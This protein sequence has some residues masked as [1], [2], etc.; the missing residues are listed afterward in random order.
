MKNNLRYIIEI[1]NDNEQY[2]V[3]NRRILLHNSDMAKTF[4][5]YRSA[6]NYYK[7]SEHYKNDDTVRI[8]KFDKSI[9]KI[10]N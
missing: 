6:Y 8:A 4:P 1:T 3:F 2:Y 7:H 10:V 9:N 5:D